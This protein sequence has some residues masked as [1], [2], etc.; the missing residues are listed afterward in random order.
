V[1]L[2][3]WREI[4][5]PVFW[6]PVLAAVIC[7]GMIGS[8]R[9]FRGKP[10][11]IRTSILICL[12][13]QI[14]VRLGTSFSHPIADPSRVLGQ[15]V[16]GVGFLGAG[17]ILARGQVL[18]GVTSAAVVWVLAAIGSAIGVDRLAEAIALA[19]FTVI[20]L[21]GVRVLEAAF[22]RLHGGSDERD[23]EDEVA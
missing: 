15:V 13:T 11:G 21:I 3:A 4:L 6:K 2:A 20:I 1:E 19:T 7:G 8:E 22:K 10:I 23:A 16:T 12:G 17:V 18:T 5:G 9:Q 14:F